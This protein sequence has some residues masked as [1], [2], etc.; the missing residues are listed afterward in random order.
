MWNQE[1]GG[2]IVFKKSI[3]S[4]QYRIYNQTD[5]PSRSNFFQSKKKLPMPQRTGSPTEFPTI[6]VP[7]NCC[8]WRLKNYT[9]DPWH[10]HGLRLARFHDFS[11]GKR[12]VPILWSWLR[13]LGCSLLQNH[14]DPPCGHQFLWKS[15]SNQPNHGRKMVEKWDEWFWFIGWNVGYFFFVLLLLDAC[16]EEMWL[17][18]QLTMDGLLTLDSL[19]GVFRD[20]KWTY[21]TWAKFYLCISWVMGILTFVISTGEIYIKK[22]EHNSRTSPSS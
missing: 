10:P 7:I 22:R 15:F 16:F 18:L 8:H 12:H 11:R 4:F 1:T 9:M 17:K 19:V 20:M 5:S 13:W 2:K 14:W 21:P 6:S 3:R